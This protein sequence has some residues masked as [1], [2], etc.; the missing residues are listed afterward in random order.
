MSFRKGKLFEVRII[1]FQAA[2]ALILLLNKEFV[3]PLQ[4]SDGIVTYPIWL[5]SIQ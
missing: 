2:K 3:C 5:I 1:Y 4:L